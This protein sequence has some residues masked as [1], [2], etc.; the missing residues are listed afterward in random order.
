MLVYTGLPTP[1][2]SQQEGTG[3]VGKAASSS[4]VG[5]AQP[6]GTSSAAG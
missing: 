1:C 4:P 3:M 5:E 6:A 2:I